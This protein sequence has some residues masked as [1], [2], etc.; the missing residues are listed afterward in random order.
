MIGH[1]APAE[2]A[3]IMAEQA[4]LK[5]LKVAD[6]ILIGVEDCLPIVAALGNMVRCARKYE[7]RS[8]RHAV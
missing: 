8:A 3:D 5:Y 7:S 6:S 1:Q 2:D 4:F